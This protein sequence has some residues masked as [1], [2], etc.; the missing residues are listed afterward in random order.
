[1]SSVE[2]RLVSVAGPLQGS[3]HFLE[4]DEFTIGRDISN[5]LPVSDTKASR[6]HSVLTRS[7][8]TWTIADCESTNGTFV[9]GVPARNR[10][11]EHGDQIEIGASK[12]LFLNQETDGHDG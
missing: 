4:T 12:F 7:G 5:S 10:V 1:M 11:L 8:E 6:R 3:V 9:N 2:P